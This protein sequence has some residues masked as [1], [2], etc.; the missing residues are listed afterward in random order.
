MIQK[1][2][3]R[4]RSWN[5]PGPSARRRNSRGKMAA[6]RRTDISLDIFGRSTRRTS[7]FLAILSSS[8]GKDSPP[9]AWAK[10]PRGRASGAGFIAAHETIPCSP[11][12]VSRQRALAG[13]RARRLFFGRKP[14]W[15]VVEPAKCNYNRLPYRCGGPS[16]ARLFSRADWRRG[17]SVSLLRMTSPV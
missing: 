11:P 7:V 3:R 16:L 14:H 5:G 8:I 15:C 1:S 13:P 10:W 17:P 2:L 12:E 4:P 6:S 9:S